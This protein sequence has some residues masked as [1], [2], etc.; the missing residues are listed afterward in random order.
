MYSDYLF[1]APCLSEGVIF[2]TVIFRMMIE[3]WKLKILQSLITQPHG[4]YY[5]LVYQ[6]LMLTAENNIH[7]GS[8]EPTV[9][10]D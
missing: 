9:R 7:K 1:S 8:L 4:N 2:T 10:G 6:S 5:V 3:V